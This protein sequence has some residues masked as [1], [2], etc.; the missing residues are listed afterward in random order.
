MVWSG[1]SVPVTPSSG[2]REV[3]GR[4]ETDAADHLGTEVPNTN[5]PITP[6][7]LFH[8]GLIEVT[9]HSSSVE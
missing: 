5:Y 2:S 1:R 6:A 8:D 9:A 4:L 7:L 3:R